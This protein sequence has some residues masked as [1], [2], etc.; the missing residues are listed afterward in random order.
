MPDKKLHI[1]QKTV[2][3]LF[4]D[5][6]AFF[7][8]PDY[9]RPYAWTDDECATLWE[10]LCLFA[11]PDDE[12]T[13]FDSNDEYFLGSIVIFKNESEKFEV[14]DGQQRLIT[15]LLMLRA[16]YKVIDDNFADFCKTLTPGIIE[17]LDIVRKSIAKTIWQTNEFG[18]PDKSCLKIDSLVAAD[19]DREEMMN[20]L[21]NGITSQKSK[22]NY[23]K[24]YKFFLKRITELRDD[25]AKFSWLIYLPIRTLNNCILLPIEA[26]NQNSA[27]RIFST[28][29][30]RGKPLSDSDIFKVQ[31]YKA[32]S[33]DDKRDY[34][35]SKWKEL[36]A[37]CEKIFSPKTGTPLDELFRRYMYYVMAKESKYIDTTVK[38]IRGFYERQ[39][40]RILKAEHEYTFANLV[41]LAEFWNNVFNQNDK[42]FSDRVLKRLFVLNYAPNNFCTYIT[43]VYFMHN[44]KSDE[45]LDDAS[46]YNF[47]NK[48]IAFVWGH[49]IIAVRNSS[50][51]KAP[52]FTEMT[53]IVR[54]KPIT[55]K[56]FT[57]DLDDMRYKLAHFNFSG[58]KRITRSM[59]AWRA[60]QFDGQ[61]L[62]PLTA[63]LEAEHMCRRYDSMPDEVY[64]S[65]GNKIFLEKKIRDMLRSYDFTA[66]RKYYLE[67]KTHIH[68][69][70]NIAQKN[71]DFTRYDIDKR[72]KAIIEDFISFVKVNN[73][74]K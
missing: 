2:L 73:L 59:L 21:R 37:L 70:Q 22:S 46:F 40:Y 66:K 74:F 47:L 51:L 42:I 32:F 60:F 53:H 34:F 63:S 31:L 55:F 58:A 48:I 10:D 54:D 67:N 65:I 3:Q 64:E 8:I 17:N 35:L 23:A 26:G 36:E 20:I 33:E 4:D 9:Q 29:N 30:D 24:N 18:Q 25:K 72:E 7:M 57:F 61:E 5:K 13:S 28:L 27:L 39:D 68:E 38:S 44:R 45:T 14:I 43:S 41:S 49:S 56:G 6:E 1:G 15:L 62:I 11:C 50:S 52:I 69:L 71:P 12:Y 19:D 16:F